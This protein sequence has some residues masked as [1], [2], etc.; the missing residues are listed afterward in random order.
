VHHTDII[1]VLV[2]L[3]IVLSLFITIRHPILSGTVVSCCF[4]NYFGGLAVEEVSICHGT[5]AIVLVASVGGI[6]RL[7]VEEVSLS[8]GAGSI[9]SVGAGGGITQVA[10]EEVSLSRGAS[11]ISSIGAGGGIS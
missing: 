9:S 10:V 1:I 4:D 8:H 6:S 7:A 2:A 11:A 5:G 3:F